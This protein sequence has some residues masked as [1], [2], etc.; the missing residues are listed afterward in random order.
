MKILLFRVSINPASLGKHNT[1]YDILYH[2]HCKGNHNRHHNIA[3]QHR[4]C[5]VCESSP[6]S[7]RS[8]YSFPISLI[9]PIPMPHP[10]PPP[11]SLPNSLIP[12][13]FSYFLLAARLSAS[14]LS[15]YQPLSTGFLTFS[16]PLQIFFSSIPGASLLPR[17]PSTRLLRSLARFST[18]SSVP[19]LHPILF[20]SS[21]SPPP[22]PSFHL[23]T[24]LLLS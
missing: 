12:H 7:S 17:L 18:P 4:I 13:L 24:P 6:L 10:C 3:S 19:F 23:R 8:E 1:S 2:E 15:S 20:S 16:S 9:S 21:I 5:L 11:P 22:P 14:L